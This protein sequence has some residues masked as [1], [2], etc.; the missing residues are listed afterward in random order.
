MCQENGRKNPGEESVGLRE[1]RVK[2]KL[3]EA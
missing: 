1:S 3:S 2:K